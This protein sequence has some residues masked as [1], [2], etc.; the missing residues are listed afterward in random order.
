VR[1][2]ACTEHLARTPQFSTEVSS[3]RITTGGPGEGDVTKGPGKVTLGECI[4][5]LDGAL[6]T[7]LGGSADGNPISVSSSAMRMPGVN[8]LGGA[9]VRLKRM[10][11][12]HDR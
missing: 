5:G 6:I 1:V 2:R 11:L 7:A 10:V 9:C 4:F 8:H 3:Q 12:N